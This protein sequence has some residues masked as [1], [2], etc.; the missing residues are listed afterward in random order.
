[1]QHAEA[2]VQPQVGRSVTV[3]FQIAENSTRE[4]TYTLTED[5]HD[6][7]EGLLS[8]DSSWGSLLLRG[9]LNEIVTFPAPEKNEIYGKIV[10]IL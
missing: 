9:R 5:A 1:M 6:P 4:E 2:L 8:K 3:R 10:S 7:K